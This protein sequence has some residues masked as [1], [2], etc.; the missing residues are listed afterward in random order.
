MQDD[1]NCKLGDKVVGKGELDNV[2]C[3]RNNCSESAALIRSGLDSIRIID[4][5]IFFNM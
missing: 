3:R 1:L 2:S 5:E 4:D